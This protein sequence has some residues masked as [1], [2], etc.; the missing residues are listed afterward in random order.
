[1][2]YIPLETLSA[3]KLLSCTRGGIATLEAGLIAVKEDQ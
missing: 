2:A 3:K 1:M